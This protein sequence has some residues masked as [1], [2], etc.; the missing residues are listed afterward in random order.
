MMQTYRASPAAGAASDSRHRTVIYLT[1]LTLT[2]AWFMA[3]PIWRSSFLVEIWPTEGWNGYFQDAAAAGLPIYPAAD[4]LIGNNYPPLS[5]YA[6]GLAGRALGFDNLF[7]GRVFSLI[8]LVSIAVEIFLS[9]RILVGGRA[10]AAIGAL[11][12]RHHG[13]Q[14]DH[15]C[16][17][18]R[19]PACRRGH[20]GGRARVV[21]LAAG[22]GR[23]RHQRCS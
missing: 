22:P 21:P 13:A 18:Q 20:Y 10:G 2:A 17:H 19:P 16:R 6:I 14:L 11:V 3:W 7:V 4:S 5:F 1:L 9:V 8:A 12:S 15:L 23:R